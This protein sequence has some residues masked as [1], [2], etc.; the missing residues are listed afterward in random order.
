MT[1]HEYLEE[2]KLDIE[3][4][5]VKQDF[6]RSFDF[7]ISQQ[8]DPVWHRVGH[9]TKL[10]IGEQYYESCSQSDDDDGNGDGNKRKGKKPDKLGYPPGIMPILEELLKWAK[11][12]HEY[13]QLHEY[14]SMMNKG[15]EE[16]R[17]Q[18]R[19]LLR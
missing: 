17:G 14:L 6:F 1:I 5:T 4:L 3:D 13:S 12:G 9:K 2:R 19:P 15:L 8:L 10:L 16:V 7:I 18:D 11:N